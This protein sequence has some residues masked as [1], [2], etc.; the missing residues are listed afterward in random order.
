MTKKTNQNLEHAFF[1]FKTTSQKKSIINLLLFVIYCRYKLFYRTSLFELRIKTTYI[2]K[3]LFEKKY[4]VT[5]S[6]PYIYFF[7]VS[8]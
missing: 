1:N 8:N 6:H 7:I 5:H 2:C 3:I 4:L